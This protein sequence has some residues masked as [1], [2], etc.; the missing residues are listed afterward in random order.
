MKII[1][2]KSAVQIEKPPRFYAYAA[3]DSENC[4][5]W[6]PTRIIQVEMQRSTLGER[7]KLRALEV[8]VYE[9]KQMF[10]IDFLSDLQRKTQERCRL[11]GIFD[12]ISMFRSWLSQVIY[13][14]FCSDAILPT[15]CV[16]KVSGSRTRWRVLSQY[17][18]GKDH[19]EY[20]GLVNG[21]FR[22][23]SSVDGNAQD[24]LGL[25]SLH[26]GSY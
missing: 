10:L 9:R 4:H 7:R 20:F 16:L 21:W 3:R 1:G 13:S 5:C 22:L 2:E 8:I 15:Q 19:D 24:S 6:S 17:L 11:F 26:R 23:F 25:R 18:G 14:P 12:V